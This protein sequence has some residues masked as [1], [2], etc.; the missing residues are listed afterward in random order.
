MVK[1]NP[2]QSCFARFVVTSG[3]KGALRSGVKSLH[4]PSSP[5]RLSH[6]PPVS[7]SRRAASFAAYTT[8]SCRAENWWTSPLW[9]TAQVWSGG[10]MGMSKTSIWVAGWMTWLHCPENHNFRR[11][12]HTHVREGRRPSRCSQAL[13][14][15]PGSGHDA[16]RT[17]RTIHG[18]RR[19]L[20]G[21]SPAAP[22]CRFCRLL[23]RPTSPSIE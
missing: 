7:R 22:S 14:R 13:T 3:H 19:K 17:L 2:G 11:Q 18:G 8:A 10:W 4:L 20:A 23:L 21:C 15:R 16:T 1:A 9:A 6:A 12:G 5:S